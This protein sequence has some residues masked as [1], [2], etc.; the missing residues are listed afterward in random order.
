MS[1]NKTEANKEREKKLKDIV[2]QVLIN[3]LVGQVYDGSKVQ[4]WIQQ[5]AHESIDRLKNEVSTELK[6]SV[7][8]IIIRKTVEQQA[9]D[10]NTSAYGDPT[11]DD[12]V[13]TTYEN[14]HLICV[15]M[16]HLVYGGDDLT[17][18]GEFLN[19]IT[20]AFSSKVPSVSATPIPGEKQHTVVRL[21]L[22]NLSSPSS[23]PVHFSYSLQPMESI[24]QRT[25]I[26]RRQFKYQH[27][28]NQRVY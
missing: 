25:L 27:Q 20:S 1:A 22:S 10:F 7:S 13:S 5:I 17:V 6:Y 3:V 9:L 18:G 23:I 16:T 11:T 14:P 4:A 2:G 21:W 19:S 15:C 8:T 24:Y 26:H 28:M 12:H